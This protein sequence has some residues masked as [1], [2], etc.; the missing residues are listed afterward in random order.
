MTKWLTW[1]EKIHRFTA[2][3]QWAVEGYHAEAIDV[4][5]E[6]NEE[7]Q[8]NPPVDLG[9]H[10]IHSG[11][12]PPSRYSISKVLSYLNVPLADVQNDFGA[13]DILPCI[14]TY[15]WR[16]EQPVPYVAN[17][18]FSLFKRM[19]IWIPPAP[20]VSQQP[21][22]D[23]VIATRPKAAKGTHKQKVAGHF[24][25]TLVRGTESRSSNPLDGEW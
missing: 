7:G 1:Q 5:I 6:D 21:T 24:S 16:L 11:E 14:E 18:K 15:L 20:Q 23:M 4:D 12:V 3:L 13:V 22:K 9:D 10:D 25:V 2:Y 17:P 8:K 19:Y